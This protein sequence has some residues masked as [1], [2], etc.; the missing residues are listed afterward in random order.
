MNS[1]G[2]ITFV[3]PL[4]LGQDGNIVYG[5]AGTIV[6][7]DTTA[8]IDFKGQAGTFTLGDEKTLTG[9]AISTGGPSGIFIFAGDGTVNGNLGIT[10]SGLT[11]VIFNGTDLVQNVTATTLTVNAGAKATIGGTTAGSVVYGGVGSLTSTGNFNGGVDFQGKGGTFTLGNNSTFK[12]SAVSSNG[13]GGIFIFAGDGTVNGNLG[14]TGAGIVQ[15]LAQVI[16]NGV[17]NVVGGVNAETL[18]VNA[19]ANAAI[20]GVTTGNVVYADAG[21][22]TTG[23]FNGGVDFQDKDG[24]FT[25]SNGSTFTGSA[26]STGGPSGIFVFAGD[27]KVTQN[28]GITGSGL[29]QVI[30]NGTDN[31]VGGVNATTL[32]I[33]AGANATITGDTTAVSAF[34]EGAGQLTSTGNFN[35]DIDFKGQGGTFTLGD[36][37]TLTGSAIST[38]KTSGIF[39]FAGDGTVKQN[40]GTNVA[41]L[42]EI[43]F[44]GAD[45]VQGGV[46]ATTLTVNANSNAK[47][48]E[49]ITGNAVYAGAGKLTS[50][51]D[52]KGNVNFNG[53]AGTFTLGNGYEIDGAVTSTGGV[54]GNLI[55]IGTG[56]VTKAIGTDAKNSP[57]L[58]SVQGDD[59]TAVTLNDD[60]FIGGI[61]FTNGGILELDGSLTTTN[62][63]FGAI[64]GVLNFTGDNSNDKFYTLNSGVTDGQNGIL[65]VLTTLTATNAGIGD[66]K[67]INIGNAGT[68]QTFTVAV[69]SAAVTLLNSANSS[70]NFLN[71]NSELTIIAPQNQ[72]VTLGGN[73]EGAAGNSGTVNL[74]G[75]GNNLRIEGNGTFGAAGSSP[76]TLN[77]SSNV[78]IADTLDVS[79]IN[80]LNIKAGGN[81]TDQSR[82]S[83][84]IAN[85]I[86]GAAGENG[87]ATYGLDAE[88]NDFNVNT[89]NMKFA[90]EDSALNLQNSSNVNNRTIT[91]QG[92]LNPGGDQF[93]KIKLTTG[94]KNLTINGADANSTLGIDG[95]R[96]KELDFVSN[97]DG[98]IDLNVGI[99]VEKI[100][101]GVKAIELGEVNADV[102][103]TRNTIY[104]ATGNINGNVDFQNNNGV[105]NLADGLQINGTVKSTGGVAGTLNFAG[106]G[107]VAG[108][109]TNIAMLKAGAGNVSLTA[110]GNYS[111]DEIQGNG[112]NS[113]T[114]AANS[115]LTGGINTSGG[116]AVNLVFTNGGGVSE[117]VGS[118]TAV[119]DITVQKGTVNFGNTVKSGNIIL[120]NGATIQVSNNVTATDISGDNDNNGTLKL[121]N[122]A[123][124]NIASTV[125]ANHI[126]NTVEVANSDATITGGVNAQTIN[127]SNAGQTATLTLGGAANVMNVTTAGNDTHTL[128]VT[129][130]TA[131]GNIG[132]ADKRLKA[133]ELTGNGT[134]NINTN[135]FYS[136]VSTANNNQGNA[137]LNVDGSI[138]YDLGG[139][140]A[141]LASVQFSGNST[142]KGDVYSTNITVDA[143]KTVTFDRGN[144]NL[145]PKNL[146]VP[147]V[148]VDV[149]SMPRSIQSFNY[150]TNVAAQTFNFA[151]A[152]SSAEFKDAVLV[153]TPITNGNL[154]FI[155]NTWI[156]QEITNVQNV[157][158][159]PNKF[160]ILEK[161]IKATNLVANNAT[162]V[163]LDNVTV[164]GNLNATNAVLDL[165]TY[166]LTYTGNVTHNGSLTLITYY[167]TTLKTGGQIVV[168]NT[169]I[170]DMSGVNNLVVQVA[171]RSDL[172]KIANG[173][174]YEVVTVEGGT[175]IPATQVTIQST[176]LNNRFIK[177]TSDNTAL[178][179]TANDGTGGG[180]GG[181]GGGGDN[182]GGGGGN[183]NGGGSGGGIVIQPVLDPSEMMNDTKGSTV[184]S[185]I[186]NQLMNSVPSFGNTTDAGKLM[187]DLGLM[188]SDEITETLERL[189]ER[190]DTN[191]VTEEIGEFNG[192]ELEDV[193]TDVAVNMDNLTSEG[194]FGRLDELG[195]DEDGLSGLNEPASTLNNNN[196][197]GRRR[198][199]QPQAVVASGDEDNIGTGIWGVPFYGVATQRSK[200]GASGYKSKTGGGIIGA[201]YAIGDTTVLGAAYTRAESKVRHKNDKTGDKTRASSNVFSVYGLYNWLQNN[202]FA[203]FIGSYGRSNIKNNE[204]RMTST[205]NQNAIGKFTN[206]S[207]SGELLGGYNYLISHLTTITP[208]FGVR[209]STFKNSSYQETGTTFQNLSVKKNT[210][211]RFEGI[212]G[213]K[214]VT[215]VVVN[216]MILRP[217][218]H[219]FVNYNF[220]NKAPNIQAYLNGMSDPLTTIK[221]KPSRMLYNLGGGVST[222]YNMV[223]LGIRYNLSLAKKYVANQGSLKIK[224]NL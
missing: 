89:A 50:M 69:N 37:K 95:N 161:D 35:G 82:T 157:Q 210:Y 46:N 128:A 171:S 215:N 57:A 48:N 139:S 187:N 104:A 126:L 203:E 142:A 24:T 132:T 118:N 124:I 186:A 103:F 116:Q 75:N 188:P 170:V 70:I 202:L 22:L 15:T 80:N 165:A 96:L 196:A 148:E 150:L 184:A 222:R 8:N 164:D 51:K 66:I 110:G 121:N 7:N 151:D 93:G 137:K 4:N 78:T 167:D 87:A 218:L 72:T 38:V 209:Y 23:D 44:N 160:T 198:I 208:M 166:K 91:L 74:D 107:Q 53:K 11:Q 125:G 21:K 174:K 163:V 64:G 123:A 146:P 176:D 183:N 92:A 156:K 9:S 189:G 190:T 101:L 65:N 140:A 185:G 177:W 6:A 83:A 216:D 105:I 112:N 224:V 25:L 20:T 76:A 30:F 158:F 47:V 84:K 195:G 67:T 98:I 55:F 206:T 200:N 63:N 179:L 173:D 18:T 191:G 5:A 58:I 114:F 197:N 31:I 136:G 130:F 117:A 223:E 131:N 178:T 205:G 39:I 152:T 68:P 27:G 181:G 213:L 1:S 180:G 113:L 12:G 97:G 40:L 56:S 29:T 127:F 16:F 111:I 135:N 149:T 144:N 99:F 102:Y 134:V 214:G 10:G 106:D 59:T 54:A 182:T 88:G 41:G 153:D 77:I 129:D 119:G 100:M 133:I 169:A 221:F 162:L 28:L 194:I 211:N 138:V 109:I 45:N 120:S 94:D 42:T 207:Y 43:I 26:I 90:N 34:Y 33:N 201:D 13:T 73:I 220:N 199:N 115:N 71:A 141:S 17:D 217:E 108:L 81:F 147:N 79:N 219:G 193:L 19:N 52:F 204:K 154:K 60:V 2:Q 86:I 14:I 192:M 155:E 143:G 85:I 122:T 62:I 159:A 3:Q 168:G 61:E 49:V 175:L 172:T 212:L 36:T 145:N 32:T